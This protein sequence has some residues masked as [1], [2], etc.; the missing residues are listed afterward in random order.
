MLQISDS[1]M[2]EWESFWLTDGKRRKWKNG[3][4]RQMGKRRKWKRVVLVKRYSSSLRYSS[5]I[6]CTRPITVHVSSSRLCIKW[7]GGTRASWARV[8]FKQYSS[9]W[10]SSTKA[11]LN[12]PFSTPACH[13]GMET[14]GTRAH[15]VQVPQKV[16]DPK[17]FPKQCS[18]TKNF[19]KNMV[20]GHFGLFA[21]SQ[22]SSSSTTSCYPLIFF[23]MFM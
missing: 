21:A 4:E 16:V 14:C 6:Y 18:V 17:L 22:L 7:K 8:L 15:Q 5:T 10:S 2:E 13:G 3:T 12:S 20:F 11:I 23:F 9:L 1:H 19:K